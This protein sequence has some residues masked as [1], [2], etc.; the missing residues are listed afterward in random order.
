MLRQYE[1]SDTSDLRKGKL[2]VSIEGYEIGEKRY[3]TVEVINCGDPVAFG[4]I[5]G[6]SRPIKTASMGPAKE[7]CWGGASS[8]CI[9]FVHSRTI[10][11][12]H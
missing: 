3:A 7:I 8:R 2:R 5:V 10:L 4:E 6:Q 12:T 1:V 11:A 9:S